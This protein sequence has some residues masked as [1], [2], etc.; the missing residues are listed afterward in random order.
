MND[1]NWV[2]I[3]EAGWSIVPSHITAMFSGNIK[4]HLMEAVP[5][6]IGE[7]QLMAANSS[8][9]SRESYDLL[10]EE[11]VRNEVVSYVKMRTIE[12]IAS[13]RCGRGVYGPFEEEVDSE[14]IVECVKGCLDR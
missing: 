10:F 8:S 7:A 5:D 13:I 14:V 12:H 4:D 3:G 2:E 6:I 11:A 1:A 9:L